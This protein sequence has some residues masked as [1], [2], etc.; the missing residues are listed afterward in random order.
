VK[1]YKSRGIRA[2]SG[3]S[4]NRNQVSSVISKATD[5]E[6]EGRRLGGMN[7]FKE[8]EAPVPFYVEA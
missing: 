6:L 8:Y 4:N 5:F 3:G 7:D 1:F 2:A